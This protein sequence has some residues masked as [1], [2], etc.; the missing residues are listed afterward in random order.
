M[1]AF[2]QAAEGIRTLDLLHGKQNVRSRASQESPG[3]ERFPSYRWSARLPS[4]YR[5][6]A[7][8]S[9]LKPDWGI[10]W[11]R[12]T[13]ALTNGWE[14]IPPHAP[15]SQWVRVPLLLLDTSSSRRRRIGSLQTPAVVLCGS[16]LGPGAGAW[17]V[18]R[19]VTTASAFARSL[20][21]ERKPPGPCRKRWAAYGAE[22]NQR[23]PLIEPNSCFSAVS[24]RDG[25]TSSAVGAGPPRKLAST[26]PTSPPPNST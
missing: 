5:E 7:G 25:P 13:P 11:I 6:I 2:S 16:G 9:G 8:V 23:A 15:G 10:M 19:A 3:K 26:L 18:A 4:F 24:S 20:G 1:Q 14:H 12:P 22:P 17:F 21:A